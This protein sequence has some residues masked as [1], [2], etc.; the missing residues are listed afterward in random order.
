[1]TDRTIHEKPYRLTDNNRKLTLCRIKTENRVQS[2]P[3][4]EKDKEGRKIR[5]LGYR[6]IFH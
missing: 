6:Y 4:Y 2:V 3:I 1:M 5:I